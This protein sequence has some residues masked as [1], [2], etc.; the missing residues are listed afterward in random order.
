[1]WPE[2]NVDSGCSQI[3]A[4][5]DDE[6]AHAQPSGSLL[7]LRWVGELDPG[8]LSSLR[9]LK[10]TRFDQG[11]GQIWTVSPAKVVFEDDLDPSGCR[12]LIEHF[13]ELSDRHFAELSGPVL[14]RGAFHHAIHGSDQPDRLTWPKGHS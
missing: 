12:V 9:P 10:L 7:E 3:T 1:M 4:L 6:Q 14:R 8:Q 2:V 5:A 13:A 11:S